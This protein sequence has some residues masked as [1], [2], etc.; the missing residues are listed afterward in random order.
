MSNNNPVQVIENVVL[1]SLV[2][3]QLWTGRAKM[4]LADLGLDSDDLPPNATLGSKPLI[5]LDELAPLRKFRY[6]MHKVCANNGTKFMGGY[7][8]AVTEARNVVTELNTITAQ[9]NACKELFLQTLSDKIKTWHDANPDWQ[10][11]MQSSTPAV[12]RIRQRI[13]FG[14]V[15]TMV[16]PPTDDLVAANF[17]TEVG[18]MGNK[19]VTEVVKEA[20]QFVKQSLKVGREDGSQKTAEPIR[21]LAKKLYSLRFLEPSLATLSEVINRVLL[22]IPTKGKIEGDH[23]FSLARVANLLADRSRMK[24]TAD[25]LQSKAIEV[26]DLVFQL[27]GKT[28]Q[29]ILDLPVGAP[30]GVQFVGDIFDDATAAAI[31]PAQA[32]VLAAVASL[33]QSGLPL[34][35]PIKSVRSS[36]VHLDF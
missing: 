24:S 32:D 35:K 7:A 10:V 23:Y 1:F 20:A 30:E 22:T 31:P 21:R 27:T 36:N 15:P 5:D 9:A 28:A 8:I 25:A 2:G 18:S 34:V 4:N 26:D 12:E 19:M 16:T 6:E 13:N 14:F 33:R 17:H 3:T 29:D 11:R